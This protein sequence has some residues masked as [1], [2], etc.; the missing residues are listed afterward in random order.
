VYALLPNKRQITYERFFRTILSAIKTHPKSI[1]IDY[2]MSI[3]Q[4]I[5]KLFPNT[6]INGCY[7][8]LI[9]NIWKHLQANKLKKDYISNY[10]IRKCFKWLR[11]L[12]FVPPEDVADAFNEVK[13]ISPPK[14]KCINEYF[15]TYYIGKLKSTSRTARKVPMF[16]IEWWNVYN[17]VLT[18]VAR[19]NNSIEA[20]HKQFQIQLNSHPTVNRLVDLFLREHNHQYLNNLR[21]ESGALIE[22]RQH[23]L[24]RDIN[25]LYNFHDDIY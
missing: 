21:N 18:D 2:E 24:E 16:K 13:R 19:T 14:F 6:R 11:A 22:R 3:L 5:T 7:F 9:Q 4:A 12:P 20:W 15:E 17:R 8:H 23:L 1:T 10:K 25:I